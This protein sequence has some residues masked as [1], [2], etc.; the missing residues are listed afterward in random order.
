MRRRKR[1]SRLGW[2]VSAGLLAVLLG[3]AWFGGSD[4]S[5]SEAAAQFP[6]PAKQRNQVVAELQ[7]LNQQ[8]IELRRLFSTGKAIVTV[9]APKQA[10]RG[11]GNS[12]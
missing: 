1:T 9:T 11:S 6:D 4:S 12:N 5:A 10:K 8:M 3:G 7:R 2:A